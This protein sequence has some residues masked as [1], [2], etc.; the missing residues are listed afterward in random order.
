MRLTSKGRYAVRAILDLTF[1]SDGRPVRIYE[2]S[3]RQLI[4]LAYLQQLFRLLRD[5]AIVN[6][7]KGPGGGYVLARPMDAISIKDILVSVGENINPA[8]DII[9]ADDIKSDTIEFILT[10][11]H[12]ETLGS[13]M[14]EYLVETSVGDL[15]RKAR[16]Q[17]VP[18][19]GVL[20]DVYIPVSPKSRSG[21]VL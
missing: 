20:D 11:T 21:L 9:G 18:K 6:S 13:L 15:I 5:G 14:H 12:F 17:T 19:D 2:I 3:E 16:G 8:R 1:W 4:P 10:K 7:I